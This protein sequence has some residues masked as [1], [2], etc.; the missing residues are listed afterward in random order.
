MI[1]FGFSAKPKAY[2]YSIFDQANL[3]EHLLQ[4]LGLNTLHVLAHNYGVTVAQELL[5]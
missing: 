1:G 4:E 2:D 3:Q 5:A